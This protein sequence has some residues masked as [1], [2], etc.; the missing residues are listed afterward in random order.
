MQLKSI[1]YRQ[2]VLYFVHSCMAH[3]P[4]K[5]LIPISCI[6]KKCVC[7]WMCMCVLMKPRLCHAWRHNPTF[8]FGKF[9]WAA[10]SRSAPS[11]EIARAILGSFNSSEPAFETK[12]LT[13][14]R[15]FFARWEESMWVPFPFWGDGESIF[16][17]YKRQFLKWTRKKVISKIKSFP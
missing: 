17:V 15:D 9:F 7:A 4:Y 12:R 11:V 8:T 1:N 13:I 14:D 6:S 16:W 3:P 2:V 10:R 5:I